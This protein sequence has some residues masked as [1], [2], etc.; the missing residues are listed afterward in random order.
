MAMNAHGA[1]G[2]PL[3]V[4]SQNS[5]IPA[6]NEKFFSLGQHSERREGAQ[7]LISGHCF[8]A[9]GWAAYDGGDRCQRTT[10]PLP[11]E[12]REN[13]EKRPECHTPFKYTP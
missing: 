5:K 10:S 6:Y 8:Q 1:G 9:P 7:G 4:L 13:S 12:S 3:F 2:V 11:V